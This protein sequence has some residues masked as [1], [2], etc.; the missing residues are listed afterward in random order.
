M[1]LIM[2]CTL[3]QKQMHKQKTHYKGKCNKSFSGIIFK[4]G[5]DPLKLGLA[6]CI[7]H[8]YPFH[9]QGIFDI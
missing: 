2:L 4:L 5:S 1:L 6:I 3:N 8:A 9:E 7:T